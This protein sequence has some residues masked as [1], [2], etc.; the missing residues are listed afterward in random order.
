ML[1]K[2]NIEAKIAEIDE[3]IAQIESGA[4][5]LSDVAEKYKIAIEKFSQ[6]ESDLDQLENQIEVLS[7]DFSE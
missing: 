1:E 5:P 7:K 2:N 3:I 4:I 6:V